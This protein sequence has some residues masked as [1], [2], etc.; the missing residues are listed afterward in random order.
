MAKRRGRHP[1]KALSAVQVRQLKAPGRHADGNGLYLV[2]DPS[3]A[4]RWVLRTIVNGRRRDIGLGG[5]SLV[6]LSEAREKATSYRKIAREGGDPLA[7]KRKAELRSLTFSEA[8]EQVFEDHKGSWRNAKHAAQWI[9][10]LRTYAFP[11]LGDRPV[12]QI[13]A[14]DI[15]ESVRKVS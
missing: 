13:E 15:L 12:D 8:A 7:E 6:S 9:T 10:T 4:R 2:I 5:T 14:P 11:K 3:G 1:E